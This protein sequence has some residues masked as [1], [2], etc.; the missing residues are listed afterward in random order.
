MSVMHGHTDFMVGYGEGEVVDAQHRFLSA[1]QRVD[2]VTSTVEF[3]V[4]ANPNGGT[5][6][7]S[8]N[9]V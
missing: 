4:S 1:V 7:E 9:S 5:R 2:C 6:I 3:I 8:V